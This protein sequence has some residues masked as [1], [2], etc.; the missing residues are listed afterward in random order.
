MITTAPTFSQIYNLL[1]AEINQ[2]YMNSRIELEGEC[3]V[4]KIKTDEPDHYAIGFSTDKPARAEGW[5]APSILF[6]F[7]EAKGLP[8]W[9]WDS[10]R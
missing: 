8:Q 10:V 5:H 6:I 2:I 1:W 9:I 3:L 7:D 4:T